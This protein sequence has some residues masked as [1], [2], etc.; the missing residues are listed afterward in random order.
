MSVH[1]KWGEIHPRTLLA[2]LASLRGQQDYLDDQTSLAI[3]RLM[4]FGRGFRY[5]GRTGSL[6]EY[7]RT[8]VAGRTRARNGYHKGFLSWT[9]P[10]FYAMHAMHVIQSLVPGLREAVYCVA[11]R[12]LGSTDSRVAAHA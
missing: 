8:P 10:R 3:L 6:A 7:E 9:S 12:P 11:E 5:A 4:A 2:D 1:L